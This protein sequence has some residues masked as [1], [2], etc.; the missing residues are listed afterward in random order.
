VRHSAPY[1]AST[2][3]S[4]DGRPA[5][6]RITHGRYATLSGFHVAG[7]D[8]AVLAPGRELLADPARLLVSRTPGRDPAEGGADVLEV[9][10]DLSPLGALGRGLHLRPR[11]ASLFDENAA[12]SVGL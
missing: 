1:E 8:A 6:I 3:E 5:L 12:A 7:A 10:G 4:E 9:V 2:D 11:G